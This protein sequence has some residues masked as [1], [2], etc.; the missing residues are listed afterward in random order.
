MNQ[1]NACYNQKI[2][3]PRIDESLALGIQMGVQGTP[4]VFVNGVE[5][6]PGKVPTYEQILQAVQVASAGN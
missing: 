5:V 1:F 4:S 6:S 3:Q 2:P